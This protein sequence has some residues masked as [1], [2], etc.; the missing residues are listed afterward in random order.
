MP[1]VRCA[2]AAEIST[3]HGRSQT[4]AIPDGSPVRAGPASERVETMSKTAQGPTIL[5]PTVE[6][7]RAITAAAKAG[8][9]A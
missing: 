6:E 9:D 5:M 4:E 2:V 1:A 8:P 7:D 3:P